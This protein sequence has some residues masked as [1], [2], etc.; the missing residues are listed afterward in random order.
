M[1]QETET[2]ASQKNPENE[3]RTNTYNDMV[4]FYV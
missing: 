1:S 3:S 4:C 2:S